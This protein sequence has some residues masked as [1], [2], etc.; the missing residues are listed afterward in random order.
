V[1]WQDDDVIEPLQIGIVVACLVLALAT[2]WL[3]VRD[4]RPN[5]PLALGLAVVEVALLVQLVAGIVLLARSDGDV[6]G[7]TFVGY[8]VGVL[9]VLPAGLLWSL[10]EKS[11]AGTAVLLVAL[12]VV[13]FLQV[14]LGQIWSAG[15]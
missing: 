2:L 8:L 12:L 15:A 14:R 5:D 4:E 1:P 6:N 11:R 7:V 10:G 9:V 13:A 3:V